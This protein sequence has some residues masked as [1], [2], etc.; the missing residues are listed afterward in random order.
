MSNK[1]LAAIFSRM[2]MY[3]HIDEVP[4]KPQAYER[5]AEA[6][7]VL[8]ES[9]KELYQKGGRKGLEEIPGVGR[10][11]AEKIE[12]YIKTGRVKEYEQLRKKIPEDMEELTRV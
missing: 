12:E 11:I 5:A 1:E 4:F 6:L 9:V 3:L 10:G 7:E 2:A 8:S